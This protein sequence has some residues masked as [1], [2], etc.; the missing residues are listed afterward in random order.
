MATFRL[1]KASAEGSQNKDL[2][3]D[4]GTSKDVPDLEFRR[5]FE[6]ADNA[7][8]EMWNKGLVAQEGQTKREA[9]ARVELCEALK[10]GPE[11]GED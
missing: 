1:Q 5:T 7:A 2:T 10:A 9:K 6:P 4:I 3:W 8:T 11:D